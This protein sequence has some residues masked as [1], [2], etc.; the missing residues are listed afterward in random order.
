[1]GCPIRCSLIAFAFLRDR[2]RVIALASP[3]RKSLQKGRNPGR[4][5]E[6][7]DG[8]GVFR[9]TLYTGYTL[10]SRFNPQI[11]VERLTADRLASYL[12]DANGDV[13]A[14][15]GLYDWNAQVAASLH[16]DLGR[17]EVVFRN[18]VDV[19]LV[20]YGK[21]QKWP[22]LWYHR[23]QL[24]L[25]R[26]GDRVWDII[27]TAR[28]RS[29]R[30]NQEVH[31]RVI[32]ELNFGFWRFLCTESYLTSLWVPA[33][34]ATFPQHPRAG[35]PRRVRADVEDQMQRMLFLRNRIAHHEPIHRRNLARDLT[36]MLELIG[37]ICTDSRAW[38]ETVSRTQALI[39]ARP[40][41]P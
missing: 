34:A 11:I 35:N 15:I 1:M 4:L 7:R 40:L 29:R 9:R 21:S 41:P 39:A 5:P 3:A 17:L 14:A 22:K 32:A 30:K 16:E 27:E 13:Q 8:S 20:A 31:G 25:G 28:R 19:A 10:M 23:R 36:M 24:F 18:A 37:W 6:G 12:D 38:V 33:I 26:H 2:S